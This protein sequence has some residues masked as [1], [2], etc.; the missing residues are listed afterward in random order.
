MRPARAAP[1]NRTAQL[2]SGARAEL[3]PGPSSP[4][5]RRARPP[6]CDLRPETRG[7]RWRVLVPLVL[8]FG[9]ACAGSGATTTPRAA[10]GSYARALDEGRYEDAY[11][12]LS[13][14]TRARISYE[15][16]LKLVQ[17]S[18]EERRQLLAAA[19]T[20]ETSSE[21]RATIT[22]RDGQKLE[23]VLEDGEWK[24][25]ASAINLYSQESPKEA[26]ESFVLAYD[27]NRYDV[28]LRFVPSDHLANMDETL[29]RAA[30]EGEQKA[31]M[32][33]IVEGLRAALPSADIEL[34]GQ[35]ATLGYAGN[36]TVELVLEAG[37]WKIEDFR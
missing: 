18:P 32:D 2:R 12:Q 35:R 31:E 16:F 15:S 27:Q 4:A 9:V 26:L 30:W 14:D 10:L 6:P 20:E 29:L 5:A 13:R 23:L 33:S 17:E 21:V 34:V 28:L 25:E 37:L 3:R 22:G 11:A 1:G 24:V 7:T 36:A 19:E 8:L